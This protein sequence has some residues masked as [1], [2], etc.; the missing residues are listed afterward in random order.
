MKKGLISEVQ[1]MQ[2]ER[3]ILQ[4]KTKTPDLP[5]TDRVQYEKEYCDED[6]K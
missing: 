1:T 2:M 3:Q 6:K 4:Y 5:S